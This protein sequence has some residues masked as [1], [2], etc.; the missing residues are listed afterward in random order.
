[1]LNKTYNPSEVESIRYQQWEEKGLF[2]NDVNSSK[3]PYTIMIPPPNVTGTLHVG[4]GLTMSLQDMLIRYNRMN[5]KDALWQPGTDH[6]GIATQRI[7]SQNLAKKGIS[8]KEIGR[9]EFLKHVWEWKEQS[10]GTITS[11]LRRLGASCAWSRERFTMDD[12]MSK[13]VLKVFVDLY[14]KGL[15]YKGNRLVNWDPNYQTAVSDIEVKFKEVKGHIWHFKYPFTEKGFTYDGDNGIHIATTRPETILA[16][17]AIAINPEDPRAK[18]LVGRKVTVPIVNREIP[19]I[20][21][22]YVDID[23]G[24]GMV[25]ITAAHDFNDYEVAMRHPEAN[26]PLINLMNPD[27]SM[28]KECPESYQ[29]LDRFEARKKIIADFKELG[30]FEKEVEHIN[31]VPH[32]ERDDTILEPYLTEQW[33]VKAAPLAKKAADAVRDGR[34][35]FVPENWSKTYFQWMDNIQDWC[36]SRQLWWGHQIPAWYRGDEVYV[37]ME[38]PEGEGWVQDEDVL[39]TWFSSALW[40]FSTLGWPEKTPELEKYYTTDVLVTGHDIIFFWV[41]RM[42]MMSL[43]FMDE[44]P[45]K[46]V[47]VHALVKDEHGQ[48]MSKSK[49]NVIDPLTIVDKFGS[50]AL[51]FTMAALAAP[52]RDVKLSEAKVESHRNFC[53]KIWNSARFAEMNEVSYDANFDT[54]TVKHPVNKW[55]IGQVGQLIS[56]VDQSYTDYRFNDMAAQLYQFTWNTFCSWYLELSK[57]LMNSDDTE[58]VAETKNTMGAVLEVLMRLMNPVMPFITEEIWQP[59]TNS[60]DNLMVQPWPTVDGWAVDKQANSDIDWLINV[61]NSIRNVRSESNVPPKARIDALYKDATDEDSSRLQTYAIFFEK[62]AGISSFTATEKQAGQTDVVAVAEGFEVI[63]PLEGIVD[64]E[65]ERKRVAKEI[66][67]FE[68]E[69][70]KIQGMLGNPSFVDRAPDHVVAEQKAKQEALMADLSKLKA[71]L[72]AR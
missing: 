67:K 12:G 40:P 20:A 68:T 4:H 15:I 55:I 14:N 17:G 25:K 11:Q 30:L 48:K 21:D 38:A 36:I 22:D 58:L 59:L 46:T 37:G 5:G 61:V 56:N 43:E 26:I 39:D 52:G 62:M 24:S 31:Q 50:D 28:S 27:A 49:G 66:E 53:T 3:T 60:S 47:Y 9:Q 29:G 72:E 32:A 45:F 10:G 65:A 33:Y 42:M 23:F 18:D 70:S 71:V 63:L 51:R 6:A 41:A 13:A 64:F 7:V 69:L 34:T 44:V 35:K 57:P 1:M 54:S 2:E 8:R 19:I 16:D